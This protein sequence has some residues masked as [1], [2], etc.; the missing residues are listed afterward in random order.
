[1]TNKKDD[2]VD[3][4]AEFAVREQRRKEYP[5]ID[6]RRLGLALCGVAVVFLVVVML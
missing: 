4:I 6:F 2:W 1:M 3:G 5:Q